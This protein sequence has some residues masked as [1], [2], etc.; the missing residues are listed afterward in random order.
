MISKQVQERLNQ[1]L[2]REFS[3]S[4]LY[5]AMASY[6]HSISL[7]G[8]AQWFEQ[9]SEEEREHAMKVYSYLQ[10]QGATVQ[11]PAIEAV[12]A[13]FNSITH[14]LE[15]TLAHEQAVTKS[16]HELFAYVREQSDFATEIFLQWFITEQVEEEASV[17][18]ILQD[19]KRVKD[20]GES[21]LRLDC[22]IA[23]RTKSPAEAVTE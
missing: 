21:L 7:N 3:A 17:E 14:V 10:E 19:T 15:E 8:F 4:Y 9:Q 16:Y 20:S 5:L 1:Q 18:A 12:N 11:F 22:K 6:C 23:K 2:N 13:K